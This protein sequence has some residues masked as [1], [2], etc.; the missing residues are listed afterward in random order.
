MP[1]DTFLLAYNFATRL[2]TLKGPTPYE[3]VCKDWPLEPDRFKLN[4]LHHNPALNN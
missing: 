1:L 3:Y 4:P 2:K